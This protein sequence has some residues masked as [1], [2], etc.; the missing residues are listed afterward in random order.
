MDEPR[1]N[2]YPPYV[3]TPEQRRRWD[4]AEAAARRVAE[5]IGGNEETV[6]LATRSLYKSDIPTGPPL[7][8]LPEPNTEVPSDN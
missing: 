8:T 1:D 5:E 7:E 3:L 2:P 6:W 4:A